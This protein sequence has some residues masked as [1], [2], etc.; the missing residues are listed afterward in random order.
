VVGA[1]DVVGSQNNAERA[2]VASGASVPGHVPP[3]SVRLMCL[4]DFRDGYGLLVHLNGDGFD[5]GN[6][7]LFDPL[8]SFLHWRARG[9]ITVSVS[10]AHKER[11][12]DRDCLSTRQFPYHH[13]W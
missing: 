4:H 10:D 6:D 12:P 11:W 9:W 1:I 7:G 3:G 5:R 8:R 13:P 2:R